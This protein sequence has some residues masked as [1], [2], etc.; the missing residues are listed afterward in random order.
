MKRLAPSSVT[1]T[2]YLAAAVALGPLSTDMYLPTFPQMAEFFNASP[3]E[4]QLTLSIFT[5]GIGGCQLIYGPLTDRFGRKPVIVAG[6]LIYVLASLACLVTVNIDQLIVLRF[7]Q[8]LGVC[9]AIVVPRAMVRDL[10]AREQAARQLSRMGTIMGLAPAIA[11][12][13]GG[14]I[15]VFYGWQSVFFILGLVGLIVALITVF[16]VDESLAEKDLN[17]VRPRHIVRNY[18]SLF[19]HREFLGYA[20]TGA[21]CFGG[22]FSFISGSPLVLIEVFGV[23]AD[24]FGY[25][26][27]IVVLGYMSGTLLGPYVTKSRGLSF[28][29]GVGTVICALGGSAMLLAAWIG[30]HSVAAVIVPMIVYTLG[31]GVVLPQS[32][33]GA[34]APFPEKAGSAS[35]LMGFLMLGFAA[36]LGFLVAYFH[37]GTQMAMVIAIG[38]MGIGSVIVFH[39]TASGS[40]EDHWQEK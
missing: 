16:L 11:P 23:A 12:V 31:L 34:M 14:Y 35:A 25:F 13:I 27:G 15:A 21:L 9:A 3:A 24:N 38:L 36:L 10:F 8:A 37:D 22:L 30:L 26:F 1:F 17:A 39:L 6:L 7:I 29:I 20:L 18:A 32:Q 5:F 19:R 28:S 4:V 2:F 40:T 33:A